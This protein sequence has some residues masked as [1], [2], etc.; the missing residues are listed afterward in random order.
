MSCRVK[1]LMERQAIYV[2]RTNELIV[3]IIFRCSE[4]I[5]KLSQNEHRTELF[6]QK[7]LK[8]SD[9]IE[10]C[11]VEGCKMYLSKKRSRLTVVV[12]RPCLMEQSYSMTNIWNCLMI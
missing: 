3:S 8:P 2:F 12:L 7:H 5:S 4:H 10:Y 6:K 1:N 11:Q 9:D